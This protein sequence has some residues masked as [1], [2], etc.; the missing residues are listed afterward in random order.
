MAIQKE[1]VASN[2]IYRLIAR[3]SLREIHETL[4]G[5]LSTFFG[6]RSGKKTL[7]VA[8][9]GPEVV[10]YSR[11]LDLVEEMIGNGNIAMFDYNPNIIAT[12]IDALVHPR[13]DPDEAVP[14]IKKKGIKERGY[15]LVDVES[16]ATINLRGLGERKI[17]VRHG[18]LSD[19]FMFSDNSVS[20][21]DA[22]LAIH[23]VTAYMD[24]LFHVVDEV[25]RVLEP[26]GLFHWGDGNVNMRYQE[27]KVHRVA[28]ALMKFYNNDVLLQDFRDPTVGSNS[29]M[30]QAFYSIDRTYDRVPVMKKA[31]Y[32]VH[33]HAMSLICSLPIYINLTKGGKILID[34]RG[35]KEQKLDEFKDY[36]RGQGFQQIEVVGRNQISLPIID[37]CMQEDRDSYLRSVRNYYGGIISLNTEVFASRPDVAERVNKADN[38]EFQDAQRGLFEYYTDPRMIVAVL[39]QRGFGEVKYQSDSRNIWF[40]VTAIKV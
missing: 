3:C 30:A 29:L 34:L 7:V 23:H 24:G 11:N 19:K 16:D 17:I 14:V 12:S 33:A 10:P 37:H 20:A 8:G 5:N 13:F 38:K 22:T 32:D 25:R 1:D 31:D 39:K 40:N 36:L 27:Q 4:L 21:F 15:E 9:Q 18:D 26:G 2:P 28:S 6:K 35:V